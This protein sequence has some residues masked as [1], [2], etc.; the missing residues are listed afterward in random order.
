MNSKNE[1]LSIGEIAKLT[2]VSIQTLYYYDRKNILKPTFIEPD[3]GYRYY[4]SDK[5]GQI[6]FIKTCVLLDIPLKEVANILLNNDM[7]HV[8]DFLKHCNEVAETKIDLLKF[9]IETFNTALQKIELGKMYQSGKIYSRDFEEKYYF[10]KSCEQ[11]LGSA[12][13]IRVM[14]NA[15]P[16]LYEY[17]H[18]HGSEY[19]YVALLGLGNLNLSSPKETNYYSFAEI[20]KPTTHKDFLFIPAGTHFFIQSESSEL[21]NANKIFSKQLKN[22]NDYIAIETQETFLSKTNLNQPVYELRLI[23]L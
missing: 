15:L 12:D 10:I 13:L 9:G 5:M 19:E 7:A 4:S 21:K 18:S 14:M 20:S 8:K 1:L 11:P 3:T 16:E 22:V 2:G 23:I 17:L 6:S